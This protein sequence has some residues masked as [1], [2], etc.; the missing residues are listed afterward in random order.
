MEKDLLVKQFKDK[1]NNGTEDEIKSRLDAAIKRKDQSSA[2]K[3]FD[4]LASY[5]KSQENRQDGNKTGK[6]DNSLYGLKTWWE[7]QK[8]RAEGGGL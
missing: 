1:K 8:K 4:E 5:R 3:L 2:S 7:F 6:K